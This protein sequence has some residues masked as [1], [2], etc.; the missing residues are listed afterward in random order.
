M[1]MKTPGK[2]LI[3]FSLAV[4]LMWQGP[5][6]YNLLTAK[7]YAS[8][9][10]LYSCTV[11]D[12]V[13]VAPKEGRG[14][15]LVDRQG[16]VYDETAQPM[17]YSTIVLEKGMM[18]DSIEG[19]RVTPEEIN[20][21]NAI[22]MRSPDDLNRKTPP[23]YLLMESIP[24][25]GELQDPDEAFVTRKTGIAIYDMETNSLDEEKTAAFME[26]LVSK[27]FVFP[28]RLAAANPTHRKEY[29]AGYLMTD[30]EGK[31]FRMVQIDGK[32]S[33][34]YIPSASGLDIKE[35]IV[36]E[37]RN[38]SLAGFLIGK[39][40][41]FYI[42]KEDFSLVPTDIKYDPFQQRFLL[43]GDMFYYTFKISDKKG[44][45]FYALRAGSFETVDTMYR[46]YP[47]DAPVPRLHFTSQNDQYVRP[48]FS[49]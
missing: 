38:K 48:R 28:V 43:V 30:A 37:L 36:T 46:E 11:H 14:T 25:G 24:D 40:D 31:L 35:I 42:L 4:L 10:T 21:N 17:F 19:R 20:F 27:G 8:A 12:F 44:E 13:S 47:Q 49:M 23:V 2:I 41:S 18:P 7:P 5:R 6:I 39:D 34:D 29:D 3:Y 33:V 16:N 15:K 26:A 1:I 9:F 32:P 45:Q 22:V